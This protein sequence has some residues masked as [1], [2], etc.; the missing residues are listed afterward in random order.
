MLALIASLTSTFLAGLA[1]SSGV[2][3]PLLKRSVQPGVAGNAA[4]DGTNYRC[5][6][7][8][9][10]FMEEWCC[11]EGYEYDSN[12]GEFTTFI[13]CPIGEAP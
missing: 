13:C 10:I 9:N 2:G 5:P 7:G 3:A 11:P 4:W 12:S 8:S 6:E 1:T